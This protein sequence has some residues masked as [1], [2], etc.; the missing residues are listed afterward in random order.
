MKDGNKCQRMIKYIHNIN[1]QVIVLAFL[2]LL[3]LMCDEAAGIKLSLFIGML[4]FLT[5]CVIDIFMNDSIKGWH[6][7]LSL[8][9]W[10]CACTIYITF[11]YMNIGDISTGASVTFLI[12][13]SIMFIESMRVFFYIA[14][15]L[16]T[17]IAIIVGWGVFLFV[18]ALL[19]LKLKYIPLFLFFKAMSLGVMVTGLKI[20]HRL[21]ISLKVTGAIVIYVG[22]VIMNILLSSHYLGT[23]NGEGIYWAFKCLYELPDTVNSKEE[24]LEVISTFLVFRIAD[25]IL[26]GFLANCVPLFRKDEKCSFY[27]E[28]S[29]KC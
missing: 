12:G 25:A 17:E 27:N 1:V 20:L 8:R 5:R 9:W 6:K 21:N 29:A 23:P 4:A 3:L 19:A 14:N 7:I 24:L 22:I 15:D 28:K 2:N 26:V 18:L 16:G 11:S 13:L 10:I